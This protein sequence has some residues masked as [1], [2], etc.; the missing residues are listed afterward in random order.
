M[1]R[2]RDLLDV[3]AS[4]ASVGEE[5]ETVATAAAVVGANDESG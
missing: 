2:Q 5:A 3:A 4:E 1:A